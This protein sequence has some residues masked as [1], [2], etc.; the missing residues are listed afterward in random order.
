MASYDPETGA[1][2]WGDKDPDDGS[3]LAST[4]SVAPPS[5]LGEESWKWLFLQPLTTG[6]E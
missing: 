4:G 3:S 2:T 6:Q 1:L 5:T